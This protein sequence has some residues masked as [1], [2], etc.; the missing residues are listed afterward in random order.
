MTSSLV[1]GLGA[2]IMAFIT[3]LTSALGIIQNRPD[4]SVIKGFEPKEENVMRIMSFNIRC[5]N[6]GSDTWEDR[7][8]IVS[9]TMLDS[10]AD[11]IGV[12]EATPEWMAA[13]KETVGDKYTYVGV[14]RDDGDD[15]GEYSA[16]FYLK[17][18]YEVCESGTFWLSET[19]DTPSR[20]WD[21]ACN[22]V[23]TWAVLQNK[24]TGEKYVHLNSHFDHI[25]IAARANSVDMI[26]DK[27]KEYTDL[28][29]VFTADMNV[30]QG[31]ENYNQFVNSGVLRDTK[32]DAENTMDYCTYHDTKPKMHEDDVI[33]YV[34]IN[35]KFDAHNYRVV[36]EGIDG[37]YV[38]DHYPIY[39]DITVK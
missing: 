4:N 9:Q 28:P 30:R 38:S 1:S 33:D 10:E 29:V 14:G 16:I 26:V 35:D 27:A 22:R 15:E 21:A 6:V 39:A 34:M 36:T 24:E 32:F 12:Q 37:R 2:I 18:V 11:S 8:G 25:G 17:D 7:I 19:P 23:C 31:S 3:F 20:G 5:A 13:L